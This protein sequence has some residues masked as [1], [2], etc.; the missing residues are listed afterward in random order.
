VL[1]T[2]SGAVFLRQAIGLLNA[3]DEMEG[4]MRRMRTGGARLVAFGIAAMPGCIVL[5]SLICQNL[6][7]GNPVKLHGHM[8]S[9]PGLRDL[10]V[11]G[12]IEFAVCLEKSLP[13]SSYLQQ[14]V[15]GQ[16]QVELRVRKGHPLLAIE[17]LSSSDLLGYPLLGPP[18]ANEIRR[19]FLPGSII[20]DPQ[21]I[22][23]NFEMLAKIVARTDGYSVFPVA[24]ET[25][26]LI[27]LPNLYFADDR[28][29]DVILVEHQNRPLSALA[30]KTADQIIE[31]LD[32]D[33]Y[34]K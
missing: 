14:R 7:S 4:T 1:P 2:A 23:D 24:F 32:P 13:S 28:I 31:I 6:A 17:D 20:Y 18:L 12:E 34:R 21:N 19:D 8:L 16:L 33:R 9:G 27:D 11:A 29:L 26:E 15:I 10:L 22:C 3:V 30:E 5:P 25:P